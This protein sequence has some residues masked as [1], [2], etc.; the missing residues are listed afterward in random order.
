MILFEKK[1]LFKDTAAVLLPQLLSLK[2]DHQSL[3]HGKKSASQSISRKFWE[4]RN[5]LSVV[6]NMHKSVKNRQS[7][8]YS[9]AAPINEND[10]L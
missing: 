9:L 4:E 10:S 2:V 1:T 6:E 8:N 3:F 7:M 5:E